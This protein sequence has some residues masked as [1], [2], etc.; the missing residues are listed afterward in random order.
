M[1]TDR[2]LPTRATGLF[3]GL[4]AF[5][6]MTHVNFLSRLWSS[7]ALQIVGFRFQIGANLKIANGHWQSEIAQRQAF[8]RTIEVVLSLKL[9]SNTFDPKFE[10]EK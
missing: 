10:V 5:D 4:L 7:F 3:G 1:L 9:S 6:S 2:L 8:C